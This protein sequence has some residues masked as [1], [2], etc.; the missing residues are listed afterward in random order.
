M[1]NFYDNPRY[2]VNKTLPMGSIAAQTSVI[3]ADTVVAR[4]TFMEPV[5]V[6]DWNVVIKTGDVFIPG[7]RK[8]YLLPSLPTGLTNINHKKSP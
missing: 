3:A 5:T 6:T 1:S 4:H 2:G 8:L 7:F